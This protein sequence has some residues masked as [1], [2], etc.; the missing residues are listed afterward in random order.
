MS[1]PISPA[2]RRARLAVLAA[3]LLAVLAPPA[4]WLD[5]RLIR[6]TLLGQGV[7]LNPEV[8]VPMPVRLAGLFT[9]LVPAVILGWGLAALLPALRA[10][11]QGALLPQVATALH[12]LGLAVMLVGVLE[13]LGRMALMAALTA[14]PGHL[15]IEFGLSAQAVILVGLGATLMALGPVLR[16]AATALEENRGFV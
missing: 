16:S 4:L 13:P 5:D 11:G 8:A 7:L 9:A 1:E 3:F 2:A 12:R 6:L 10:I 14:R 15:L